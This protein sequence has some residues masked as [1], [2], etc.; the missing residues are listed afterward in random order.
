MRLAEDIGFMPPCVFILVILLGV[1][2]LRERGCYFSIKLY[3]SYL[4]KS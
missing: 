4:M 2:E 1:N 3:L